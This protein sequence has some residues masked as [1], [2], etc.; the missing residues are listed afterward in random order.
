MT[1]ASILSSLPQVRTGK[2]R[3]LAVTDARRSPAAAELPT[4]MEACAQGYE[5]ATWYGLLAPAKTPAPIVRQL[6]MEVV[7]IL[8]HPEVNERLSREG[9]DPVGNTPQEFASYIKSEIAKWAKVVK[10]ANIQVN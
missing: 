9:A 6:N 7:A 3:A 5:S 4:T 10:A 8:K 1:F 2:L